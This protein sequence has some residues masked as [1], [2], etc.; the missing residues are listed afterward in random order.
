MQIGNESVWIEHEKCS[1]YLD[2]YFAA[3]F[4]DRLINNKNT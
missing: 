1:K 2:L 4:V 3:K